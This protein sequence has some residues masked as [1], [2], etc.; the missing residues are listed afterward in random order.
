MAGATGASTPV[1]T[2]S[3][4]AANTFKAVAEEWY[5]NAEK[6]GL[7]LATLKKSP[8]CLPLS[9]RRS[10]ID[11]SQIFLRMSCWRFFVSLKFGVNMNPPNAFAAHADRYS[12]MSS[13]RRAP[14]AT[15]R[16]IFAGR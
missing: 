11:Q 15:Y 12:A 5:A 14:I 3:V 16:L 9:M 13:P 10:A 7:A 6:Q 1:I 8:G 4:A 2:A